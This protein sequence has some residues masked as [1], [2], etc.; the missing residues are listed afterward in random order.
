M[1]RHLVQQ[2]DKPVTMTGLQRRTRPF[3]HT[4]IGHLSF[5]LEDSLRDSRTER[6]GIDCK[7]RESRCIGTVSR[8]Y[9]VTP[10]LGSTKI[11]LGTI[12]THTYVLP[13][14]IVR[15]RSPASTKEGSS[16]LPLT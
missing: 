13:V 10:Q 2:A 12:D 7:K 14:S 16:V 3:L 6:L 1:R 9:T 8:P 15:G 5:G 4:G 11:Y